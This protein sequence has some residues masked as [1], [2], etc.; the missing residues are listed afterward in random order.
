MPLRAVRSTSS[1]ALWDAFTD[2]FFADNAGVSGPGGFT[3]FA[4][5][6]H[7]VQH[8][9][10]YRAAAERGVGAWLGPPV[11]FFS[12]LPRLFDI[13]QRPVGLLRRQHVIDD[14]AM[15]LAHPAAQ[16]RAAFDRRG[17]GRAHDHLIGEM[18]AE[19]VSPDDLQAALAQ[20]D[21]DA[22]SR[23]RDDTC[24]AVYRGYLDWLAEQDRYDPR[25]IHALVAAGT[26]A[27]GLA[28]AL[29]GCRRLHVYG[30]TTLRT[31]RRLLAALRDQAEVEV[32]AYVP[33]SPDAAEWT[34]VVDEV[35]ELV[36][37][38]TAID[39]QP[40][41]DERR[42][43]DWV[44]VQVKRQIVERRTPP[45]H[46]AV[47]ARSGREDNRAAHEILTQA[48]IP[49]TARLRAGLDEVPALKAIL[50]LFRGAAH[51]WPYR[52]LRQVLSSPYFDLATDLRGLDRLA[53]DRRIVGVAAWGEALG[54]KGE[55][56]ERLRAFAVKADGLA[57]ER[58]PRDWIALTRELLD[59]GWFGFR[60][61]VCRVGGGDDSRL[62][63][64]RLDQQAIAA[65][66]ELLAEWHDAEP[67]GPP[68]P[69]R[70][71]HGRLRRFLAANEIALSTPLR[72]GVQILE[73]HEAALIP[74]AHVFVIHANDGE[75]PRRPGSGWLFTDAELRRLRDAGLPLADRDEALRRERV[76][77]HSVTSAPRVSISYRT[78]DPSGVP[79]LPSLLVPS[80]DE[81]SEIPRTQFVW[82]DAV[83][84][85]YADRYATRALLAARRAG[86]AA[87]VAVPRVARIHHAILNAIA[88]RTRNEVIGS[89]WSGLVRDPTVIDWL[90][91]RFGVDYRWSA[92]TLEKYAQNPFIFF[93]D[94]VLELEEQE[95]AEEE[96]SPLAFGGV[97]HALLERFYREGAA[98]LGDGFDATA[99]ALYERVTD[100]VFAEREAGTDWLGVEVLWAVTRRDIRQRV[101]EFLAWELPRLR[102]RRPAHFEYAFG[103][104]PDLWIDGV[105]VRGTAARLRLI[106]RIDR[107]DQD[108]GGALHVVDYKSG[109]TPSPRG[110]GDGAALQGPL[111]MAAVGKSLNARVATAVYLSIKQTRRAAEVRWG[112]DA[113]ERALQIA[114][115]IPSRVRAGR[116]EPAAAASS[117]WPGYW[118]G[119]DICRV[120]SVLGEGGSRFDE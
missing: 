104:E 16:Q 44:A 35:S 28:T 45:D 17:V 27:G 32:I 23:R 13:G 78:A 8:D 106:G 73:A 54:D 3:A 40:A 14:L 67:D 51:D 93:V 64:V 26:A 21:G 101:G 117:K 70:D 96:T 111:Y 108:S 84:P 34:A 94:K 105:D 74:F 86:G 60:A 109:G 31:R 97:A 79:L 6:T 66:A 83:T 1:R 56:A 42:E 81:S 119:L 92:S 88:E 99:Q 46:I 118:P 48:G 62:D 24:V 80:H 112:D 87:P 18:L 107:I 91:R 37:T 110:Y 53:H 114:F 116:F 65:F 41:P 89:P 15:R 59:P 102:D 85:A 20:L 82:K 19:A 49:A 76:L 43:L 7:R 71:W 50:S 47:V 75:F 77:W 9:A 69:P 29:G 38:A 33:A 22:F 120:K 103:G 61:Q 58:A 11:A 5:L 90:G 39:V 2:A 100:A 98:T 12:D 115:T 10:L 57:A 36:G 4:W 63:V 113:C 25:A 68:V 52:Q 55:T 72:T 95:E 30:L